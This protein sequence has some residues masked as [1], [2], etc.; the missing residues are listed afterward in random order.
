MYRCACEKMFT[1]WI[2]YR[3]A[4]GEQMLASAVEFRYH[5]LMSCHKYSGFKAVNKP[6][7]HYSVFA[8]YCIS[9]YSSPISSN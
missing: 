2:L 3:H 5:S 4:V 7:T 6:I 1:F 9:T 8:K